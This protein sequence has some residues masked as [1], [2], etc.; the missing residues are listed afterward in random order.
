MELEVRQSPPQSPRTVQV[1]QKPA[2]VNLG[3]EYEAI[4]NMVDEKYK[5]I[6]QQR[7]SENAKTLNSALSEHRETI[8]TIFNEQIT[9]RLNL[10]LTDLAYAKQSITALQ[11]DNLEL[12]QKIASLD[13]GATFLKYAAIT[14]F[15]ALLIGAVATSGK[16]MAMINH[17]I[18][19]NIK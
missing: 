2:Q 8:T 11:K 18:N 4:K 13:S 17:V 5:Q 19:Q 3:P 16:I 1:S 12:K 6:Q 9:E 15:F 10:L 7:N 14:S